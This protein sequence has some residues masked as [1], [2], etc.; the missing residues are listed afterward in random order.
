MDSHMTSF[1]PF[2]FI[3]IIIFKKYSQRL[4]FYNCSKGVFFC[5][6]SNTQGVSKLIAFVEESRNVLT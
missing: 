5:Y 3:N 2:L 4:V 6:L 1:F